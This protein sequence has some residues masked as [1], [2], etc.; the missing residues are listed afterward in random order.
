VHAL[1]ERRRTVADADD[2][3]ANGTHELLLGGRW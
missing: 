2:G 1:D 3:D